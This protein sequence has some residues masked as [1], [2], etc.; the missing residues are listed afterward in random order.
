MIRLSIEAEEPG[1]HLAIPEPLADGLRLEAVDVA[2]QF[3]AG[4]D[5]DRVRIVRVH[6]VSDQV[7]RLAD[8]QAVTASGVAPAPRD[9]EHDLEARS[10]RDQPV[11]QGEAIA[12]QLGFR[13]RQQA[14][15]GQ[16][17]VTADAIVLQDELEVGSRGRRQAPRERR[18]HVFRE[19]AW[20]LP[21]N[22]ESRIAG[23][24][25]AAQDGAGPGAVQRGEFLVIEVSESGAIVR[26]AQ[27]TDRP[28]RTVIHRIRRPPGQEQFGRVRRMIDTVI[29]LRLQWQPAPRPAEL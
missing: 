13:E 2:D 5:P 23:V 1:R 11:D 24:A 8:N 25:I 17:G 15:G 27:E 20:R 14:H 19:A 7:E 16:G 9:L 10:R 21:L 26:L 29:Q 18:E 28:A 6:R 3:T 12:R 4:V 22:V